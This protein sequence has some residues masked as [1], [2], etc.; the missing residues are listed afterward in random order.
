MLDDDAR[1]FISTR[2][3]IL[4]RTS[5]SLNGL[6]EG[7]E[8]RQ[9]AKVPQERSTIRAELDAY[10]AK[11]FGLNLEKLRYILDPTMEYG[12]D[13]PTE[14]FKVLKQNDLARYGEFRTKRL[15]LEAWDRL[16]GSA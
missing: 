14:T 2:V 11:L 6:L 4:S 12:H 13:Y 8:A 16:F 15:V 7:S 5:R 10:I 3:A 9:L 1:S